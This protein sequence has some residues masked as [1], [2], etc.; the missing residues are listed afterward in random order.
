MSDFV[1]D[2]IS[3]R[4]EGN[5]RQT[6]G[7]VM[8]AIKRQPFSFQVK[9]THPALSLKCGLRVS[10]CIYQYEDQCFQSRNRRNEVCISEYLLV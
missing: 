1:G 8:Q 7:V 9:V 3:D 6:A 5:V 4:T 2:H 10:V